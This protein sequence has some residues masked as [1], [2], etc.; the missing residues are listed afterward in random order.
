M[1]TYKLIILMQ[2]TFLY[3]FPILIYVSS[4]N[5]ISHIARFIFISNIKLSLN[6]VRSFWV[7][8]IPHR[9][10]SNR[11]GKSLFLS[12][13]SRTNCSADSL[14]SNFTGITFGTIATFST[15]IVGCP[16]LS[17]MIFSTIFTAP[18]FDFWSHPPITTSSDAVSWGL[19]GFF[20]ID[21][22]TS[23]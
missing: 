1:V 11:C 12:A 5:I 21:A 6:A 16:G 19:W 17:S 15:N 14:V 2:N 23:S 7:L 4:N 22:R 3:I 9:K 8:L 18:S 20:P 10:L 13:C